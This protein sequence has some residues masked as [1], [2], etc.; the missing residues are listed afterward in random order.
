MSA[1]TTSKAEWLVKMEAGRTTWAALAAAVGDDGW[2]QPGPAGDWSFKD[3]A[4]HLNS[5]RELTVS[6]LEAAA[7]DKPAPR[8][9]WPV[10]MGE[11]TPAGVEE[12]NGWFHER[13]HDRSTAGILAET[14][15]Q[16]ERIRAAVEAIPEEELEK[17]Y[18]WL[19]GYP[20]SAVIA[21]TLEHLHEDHEPAIRAQLASRSLAPRTCRGR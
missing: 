14:R 16:F 19:E 6:R 5:W 11:E 7:G 1:E 2:D 4:A 10:G 3:V 18:P 13:D 20:L 17:V 15:D 12:I 8:P 21:G 9:P